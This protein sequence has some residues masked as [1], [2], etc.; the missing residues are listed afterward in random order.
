LTRCALGG[1][2]ARRRLPGEARGGR[3][4][5]ESGGKSDVQG[6]ELVAIHKPYQLA[7]RHPAEFPEGLMNRR[8]R[9]I[10]G[11]GFRR[12]VETDDRQIAG[13]PESSR[14]RRVEC[15]DGHAIVKGKN[16]CRRGSQSEQALGAGDASLDKEI[17]L[18]LERRIRHNARFRESGVVALKSRPGGSTV[19][20][21]GDDSDAAMP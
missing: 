8:E 18:H 9:G 13:E 2:A 21:A 12:V 17:R 6:L 3:T 4:N 14:P 11:L 1:H 7:D 5:Y 20:A 10:S 19:P 15:P 16:R